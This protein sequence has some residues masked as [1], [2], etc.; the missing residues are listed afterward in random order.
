MGRHLSASDFHSVSTAGFAAHLGMK[1]RVWHSSLQGCLT[2]LGGVINEIKQVFN[3]SHN[4]LR[5]RNAI[6]NFL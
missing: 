4:F 5:L 1:C 6:L 2:H 3:C